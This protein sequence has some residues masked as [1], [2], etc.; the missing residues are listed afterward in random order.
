MREYLL[1]VLFG[2]KT[3]LT[4]FRFCGV[5]V[6]LLTT[7]G[8]LWAQGQTI[9]GQVTDENNEGLPGVSI[10]VKGTGSGTVTDVNGDFRIT[11]SGE[12][13]ALVF[14]SVGYETVTEEVGNRSVINVSLLPD[15]TQLSEVVVTAL[16]VERQ[17]QSLGYAVSE[18]QGSEVAE[19][20]LIN[21]VLALQGKAAGLS[22]GGTDGGSF[23]GSKI[24][25]R[26]QSTL[27]SNN[28]P[29]F[30]VDGVILDNQTSGESEWNASSVD[31][32]NELKNLNPDNFESVSVL[33]GAAATALYGSRGLNGAIVITTKS[34][35]GKKGLGVSVSQT[36]GIEHVYDTPDLQNEFGEGALAGYIDYGDNA[37]NTNQFYAREVNGTVM[38]SLVHP[39]SGFSFGPRFDGRDIEDYDG[40]ITS[41]NARPDNMKEAFDLGVNTNT[42]VSIQGGTEKTQM[43]LS[44]SHNMRNGWYPRN[45]FTRD[46]LLLKA[47]TWLSDRVKLSGSVAYTQSNPQNPAGNLAGM[48]PEGGVSRSYNTEKY[49]D[50]YTADH[51]GVP[52][53]NFND[54]LG[55]VP[56][57]GTWFGIYNNDYNREEV[58]VRPIVNLTADIT[59]WFNVT[60]EGN[61][62]IFSYEYEAKELGQG[63]ANEGGFYSIEQYQKKQQTG[64]LLLN[65]I[66]NFGDFSASFTTG[67][68]IFH[69]G[70]NKT[71]IRTDGGL[72][73]PGQYFISNSIN[74]PRY[75]DDVGVSATKQINSLYFFLNT[76]WKNQLY[77]DITGRNDWSSA[78]VYAD[79]SGDYSYF[80]P[81]VSSSWLFSETFD[82]P[83]FLST[84]RIRASLAQVGNDT[85]PYSINSAYSLNSLIQSN[86]NAYRMYYNQLT[87]IDPGL[88]P[89]KKNAI[90]LGTALGFVNDRVLLDFTW[91]KENTKNQIV[92]IPAPQ[93]S[94]VTRQLINAGNIQN[95][96][97]EIA[98]KTTPVLNQNF[99]WDLDFNYWRN[100]NKILSLHPD[101]GDYKSLAGNP[102]Y[103]NYRIGTVAWIGGAYGELLSDIMPATN[104]EGQ[105]ILTYS[106]SRRG[107]YFQ[108][109]GEVE[110]I[111]NINP[112]F[113]GSV[114][115]TFSYKGFNMSFLID[116]RFGGYLASYNNRYGT[117]YGYLETSTKGLDEEHGGITWTSEYDGVTYHD[118]VIPDGVFADGTVIDLANGESQDVSGL[119][120]QE[121]YEQGY[122]EPTHASYFTYFTN[123]WGQGVINDD[124]FSEVNYVSLRQLSIG[125]TF[126]SSLT[127]KLKIENLNVSLM[128]RN[129]AYLY[130]SLPNNL[131]PESTRGNRSDYSYFERSFAPYVASYAMTVRFN[132]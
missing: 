43:Y 72:V 64:K 110:R 88:Q 19:T 96:G 87:M 80:Y 24:S 33:K 29:I 25:I 44:L 76:S 14:S 105:K 132:F 99:R 60:L 65:F 130:N 106:N 126:P 100:R 28:Q 114:S 95:T 46:N 119:T 35:S 101:V 3:K 58:T 104:E 85:D 61:M 79:G 36:V 97:I 116:M 55:N 73:I 13:P 67:G 102:T 81:S 15:L 21:P 23:G 38:P 45:D 78:L 118:G 112:D 8:V 71:S 53:T 82:M 115:N 113:E 12:N 7:S 54:E 98:L 66:Q 120:Y 34:G 39:W 49:R 107:A 32:G 62:N 93:S 31:Y 18:I 1:D 2:S 22:I 47:S 125:Y 90:E 30:V 131:N 111:G 103:G 91:Y 4:L 48:Y 41:Y 86:G 89:E 20:N 16:G 51:G 128:G 40:S 10:L 26:G 56:N 69:T 37:Y 52:S 129:L 94:G 83:S 5:V 70:A 27:G 11:V 57:A 63:Y 108:R 6:F 123:S 121:A 75:G 42:N 68:E 50:L 109:S 74:T 17:E 117:A 9:T 122:V 124:W 77:L 92:D 84:G 127:E 59:D